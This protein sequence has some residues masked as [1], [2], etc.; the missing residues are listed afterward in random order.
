[1]EVERVTSLSLKELAHLKPR[2]SPRSCEKR[3]AELGN[4]VV[5]WTVVCF[6]CSQQLVPWT[7]SVWHCSP[8]LLKELVAV[9]I[10]LL[11]TG[12]LP[13]TLII[14]C[15]ACGGLACFCGSE[16]LW[17]AI[18]CTLHTLRPNSQAVSQSKHFVCK[19]LQQVLHRRRP[20]LP[21]D[22][23]WRDG[24]TGSELAIF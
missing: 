1:M 5:S 14:Y 7:P 2:K 23:H 10:K 21:S 24:C 17:R 20:C 8:Q 18:L 19:T 22:R 16:G 13:T 4:H 11:C 3:E 12:W 6:S 9:Y 15:S